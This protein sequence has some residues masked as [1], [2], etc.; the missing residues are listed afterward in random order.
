M[1]SIP[2]EKKKMAVSF[3]WTGL[4]FPSFKLSRWT[5]AGV[6]GRI[7]LG[8]EKNGEKTGAGKFGRKAS[9]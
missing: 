6:I 7:V 2:A 5:L 8:A 1:G 3:F 9:R 4:F